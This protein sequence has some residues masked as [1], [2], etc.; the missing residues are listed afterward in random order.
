M[1][2]KIFATMGVLGLVSF[3]VYKTYTPQENSSESKRVL[4]DLIKDTSV[5][6]DQGEGDEGDK[7][8]DNPRAAADLRFEMTKDAALGYPPT[9]RNIDAYNQIQEWQ[10]A[11]SQRRSAIPSVQWTER[12]PTNTGGRTRAIMFDPNDPTSKKVWA[13]AVGGGLW[14]S[15]DITDP[16]FRWRQ[17]DDIMTNLAVSTLTHDPSNTQ[18]YYLGTGLGYT[19]NIQGLGIWK[20][21]D[22]GATWSQ[23]SSTNNSD[24]FFVQKIEVTSNGVVL[25]ST[26]TGLMRSTDGGDSWQRVIS[27]RMGDIEI[28]SNGIIYATAGA[29]SPGDIYRSNN[30]GL[31][32]ETISPSEPSARVEIAI[33][34][35]NPEVV[36][37][38]SQSLSAGGSRAD[39]GYFI[40]STDGGDT[41][42]DITI[43][44]Y[45]IPAG[46][47]ACETGEDHFT[48]GQAFFNL[49]LSVHPEDEDIVFVGG[50]NM[51]KSTDGGDT[52]ETITDW[53][54]AGCDDFVHADQHEIVVRPNFPNE[55]VIG[56]D[57]GVYYSKDAGSS[58]NPDFDAR[59]L[60]YNTALFYSVAMTNE[61]NSN[62]FYAGAQDNGTQ[63]FSTVGLNS[64]TE[65]F[66]GDGGFCFVDQDDPNIVILS[67]TNNNYFLSV[68]GG[69]GIARQLI[70]DDDRGSFINKAAYDSK[71]NTFYSGAD[72]NQIYRI[73]NIGATPDATELLDIGLSGGA[74]TA[75]TISPHTESTIFV[76]TRS[77]ASRI[78][79]IDNAAGENPT[80]TNITG[81]IDAGRGAFMTSIAV[82]ATDDQLLITFSNYG[83]ISVFETTDGGANWVNK[84]DNLPD[85]PINWAIYNPND[86]E[87]VMLATELGVWS[88]TSISS[89]NP[90]WEPTNSGLASVRTDMLQYRTSDETVAAA[91]YGRGLFTT[92]VFARTIDADFKTE[93]VVSYVGV[94]VNFEDA[95]LLPNDS[96]SWTFGDGGT[97]NA[98]NPAYSYSTPGTYDVSLTIDNG[99]STET[100]TGYVTILPVRTAPFTLA[101]GGDFESNQSDFTSR[102]LVNNLNVWELG[103]PSNRLAT[104]SSGT[105]AWKTDLDGDLD[106]IGERYSS[107]LYTPAFDLSNVNRDYTIKFKKSIENSFCNGPYALQM[108][109]SI[110]GGANWFRLGSAQPEF[111]AVNWYNRSDAN[112]CA[113]ATSI[114]SDGEGWSEVVL[115]DNNLDFSTDNEDTELKINFLAGQPHVAFRF[116]V[117]V[118]PGFTTYE[119]D[120]FMIDDFE[121]VANA[122][123]ANFESN[124]Q[125]GFTGTPIQFT[126]LSNGATS[127]L[128]NFGDGTTS[129][130]ESPTHSYQVAGQ[131][132]VSLTV[133]GTTSTTQTDYINI[134]PERAVPY[135]LSAGGDF[136]SNLTDFAAENLAG[137]GF[138]LGSSSI[139]GKDGTASG[140][141]A[142]VT[143]LDATTY[144][145]DSEAR[146]YTPGFSFLTLGQYTLEFKA[147]FSFEPTWDG[148]IVQYSTDKG[149]TWTK[150]N[151]RIESGWY[152]QTSDAES[153]FGVSVPMFSGNTGGEFETFSTDV[154]FLAQNESVAFR[155]LFLTDASVTDAGVAIDDFKVDGP[156]PGPGVAGFDFAGNTGC[157]GQQ[158]VFTNTSTGTITDLVWDFGANA[159]PASATGQGPHTVAY[160]GNGTSTVSLTITSPVNGQTIEQKVDIISTVPNFN[161][162]FTQEQDLGNRTTV[163]T[164]S[165]GD[166]YQ[167]LTTGN[168]IIPGATNQQ[169]IA[170]ETGVYR[171]EVTIGGCTRLS[172]IAQIITSTE[173][174]QAF[175]KNVSVFPN[176]TD[177]LFKV[178]ISDPVFGKLTLNVFDNAGNR[179]ISKSVSKS[180][181]DEEYELNIATVQSG[182]YLVEVVTDKARTVKK[183][184]K[185]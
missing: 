39:V 75:L 155:F 6:S 173:E 74:I 131:F 149:N 17:E 22:A 142:W 79:R 102:A 160:S 104:T 15:N 30:E 70:D 40:K 65:L 127:Y 111:G 121:I 28:A 78:F 56:N 164:A 37:A 132:D 159:T 19:T 23:I 64:T 34:P 50:I 176:P 179:V 2:K 84:E 42:S 117:G 97:S 44:R 113:V 106:D 138:E 180:S 77:N 110:D 148:F 139:T 45:V 92:N 152:N 115:P 68:N 182:V 67:T 88:T 119:R 83:A 93:Q 21:S 25:A 90:N 63:V 99:N 147:K 31:T 134:L 1:R 95:S 53:L 169:F 48:R 170:D 52:W 105:N 165:E 32:W 107:A 145:D 112:G 54:G 76:G 38:V 43:P 109:Y 10:K 163:L 137:T 116:V 144:V 153:V 122:P 125:I 120:G 20:S 172:N 103:S 16:A 129:T 136:E 178:N 55:I 130:E 35:S 162:T 85:M 167:W 156:T 12:G 13:G 101:D 81:S 123:E 141:N 18:V 46:E 26:L 3:I 86:Y 185:K 135:E 150:L 5:V 126:Y 47:G 11:Q 73:K 61:L 27:N 82:G 151:N 171:V 98:Q 29:S 66:G 9:N 94:P 114:F 154:S 133:D 49:I 161:P 91:T 174:D 33:S 14:Y 72:E 36:Y 89:A 100:K 143:D 108:Q 80:V 87:Q 183:I 7:E 57:G 140:N 69:N 71:T 128:W 177:G 59:N 62:R 166:S 96:W 41:W 4:S 184:I 181:F 8:V 168:T 146:L 124:S 60:G 157:S 51:T 58:D 158:V 175:E 118:A 24:F